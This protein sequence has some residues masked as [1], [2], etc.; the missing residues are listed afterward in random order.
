MKKAILYCIFFLLNCLNGSSQEIINMP[1][2]ITNESIQQIRTSG[3][4]NILGFQMLNHGAGNTAILQQTGNQNKAGISQQNDAGPATGNLSSTVQSGNSNE[5]TIG[6]IGTRNLLI[7]FQLGYMATETGR[8][9]GNHFGYGLGNGNGNAFAY[10]HTKGGETYWVNGEGNKLT[11]SQDGNNNS[12]MAVQEGTDNT[13]SAEQKG[14]N[15]Y[16]LVLQ[17]GKNNSVTGFKQEN[18]SGQILYDTII[19]NGE[20]LSLNSTE[21]SK[22]KPN[23]N[24][25]TQSGINLSLDINNGFLNTMGGIAIN[26]TGKDMKVVVDQSYFSNPMK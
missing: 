4:D 12:V 22:A 14:S 8:N 7:G 26:Q 15:N 6:Q 10:G 16:L 11:V 20:N 23:G 2:T 5:M 25:F 19:Q 13:I 24:T 9:Q 18:E 21:A 17:N 3:M 1:G